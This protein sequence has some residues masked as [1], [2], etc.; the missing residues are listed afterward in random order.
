MQIYWIGGSPCAGKSAI[1]EILSK[2]HGLTYYKVD[3]HFER[4]IRMANADEHPVCMDFLTL[5][6]DQVWMAPVQ[7]Q[8]EREILIY[9]ELFDFVLADLLRVEKPVLVEGAGCLPEL[10]Y[11]YTGLGQK[12]VWIVPTETFQRYH[13]GQ[14]SWAKNIIKDCRDPQQAY[15]LWMSRDVAYAKTV[16]KQCSDLNLPFLVVNGETSIKE[17]AAWAAEQLGLG[18]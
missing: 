14:R 2:K 11:P 13:Y 4:H 16:Q 8:L 10:V 18:V 5:D 7:T 15:D 12:A 3:D 17:N 9:R 6:V 1:A